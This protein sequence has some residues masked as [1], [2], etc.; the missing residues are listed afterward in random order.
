[1]TNPYRELKEVAQRHEMDV[2]EVIHALLST[3]YMDCCPYCYNQ[4]Q[5]D[6][7]LEGFQHMAENL[8]FCRSI[9]RKKVS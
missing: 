4:M 3:A 8:E 2:E 1:M 9:F 5:S 7:F 6:A